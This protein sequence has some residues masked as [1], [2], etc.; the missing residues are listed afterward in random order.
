MLVIPSDGNDSKTMNN[1]LKI[2]NTKSQLKINNELIINKQLKLK[3]LEK[4]L[5][6]RNFDLKTSFLFRNGRIK[7]SVHTYIGQEAVAVGISENLISGDY[8]ISTHRCH[9]H[10]LAK[11]ADPK[12]L[13]SEIFGKVDGYSKGRGG[14]MHI[15]SK[16]IN[17]IATPI[18]GGGIPIGVG[19]S[20]GLKKEKSRNIVIVFIG[21]GATNQGTFHES[22]NLASI[23]KLPVLFVCENNKYSVSTDF[24]YSFNIPKISIRSSSYGIEGITI[25]GNNVEEVFI[26]SKELIKKARNGEGPSLIEAITYR[27][28]GHYTGEPAIYRDK[29]ELKEWMEK[30]PIKNYK[31]K[32]VIENIMDKEQIDIM[33]KEICRQLDNAIEFASNSKEPLAE[34]YVKYLYKERDL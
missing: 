5:L 32:L 33:E 16:D 22:L 4:M 1:K 9:G 6:L 7:G 31:E 12:K 24:S 21:E 11:G 23:F 15:T 14:S 25:D 8:F 10:A 18:V 17:F 19:I 26:V 34:D 20:L 2:N 28:E 3:L 30:C 29:K 27:W 13:Y